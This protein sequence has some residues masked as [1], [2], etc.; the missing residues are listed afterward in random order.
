M[1]KPIDEIP[2]NEG[3][4][5]YRGKVR[6]DILEAISRDINMFEFVGDYNFKTLAGTAREEA[7]RIAC[8]IVAKWAKDHPEYKIRYKNWEPTGWDIEYVLQLIKI[9][10]IKGET[11]GERRVFCKIKPDME[12]I[13]RVYAERHC[14]E[15]EERQ[16]RCGFGG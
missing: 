7:R 14:K 15:Y 1:I 16:K 11:P 4:G 3:K 6:A 5:T 12:S 2:E 13:I 10:S 9:Y 8:R